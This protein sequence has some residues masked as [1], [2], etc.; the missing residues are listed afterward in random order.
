LV[1]RGFNRRGPGRIA[2]D[3][4]TRFNVRAIAGPGPGLPPDARRD[5]PLLLAVESIGTRTAAALKRSLVQ[6]GGD[7][8]F[9]GRRTRSN[10]FEP[11]SLTPTIVTSTVKPPLLLTGT[12]DVFARLFLAAEP[13]PGLWQALSHVLVSYSQAVE[14]RSPTRVMGILNVTPDSFSD[15]ALYLDPGAAEERAHQMVEEGAQIL[16]IG[17]EST[18]PGSD[19]VP[20]EEELRRVLPVVQRLSG[21]VKAEISVDTTKAA[22]ARACLDAGA[23]IFNDVSGLTFEPELAHVVAEAGATLALMHM[24]GTPRTMQQDPHYDDVV[25]DTMRFLR[26]QLRVAMNAGIP[27]HRLWIDPGFGFGKTIAHN[28][29]ILR[30]LREYTSI[31]PPVLIGTSRKSTIGRVLGDL[32]PDQRLEGTAATVA[33]AITHGAR[34]VRVHDVREM[35]RVARMTDAVMGRQTSDSGDEASGQNSLQPMFH[36]DS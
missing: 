1:A 17:G 25:A 31:G 13:R 23:T 24:L 35:A 6:F 33:I 15:G 2:T 16:D 30:R 26:R 32:P 36:R 5:C 21:R 11:R 14:D 18:R 7:A 3:P 10:L 19:P 34:I 12:P 22:V 9:A 20:A 27:E 29:Q 28:L 4:H 8:F